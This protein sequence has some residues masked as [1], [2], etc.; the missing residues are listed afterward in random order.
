M[1]RA[2]ENLRKKLESM[3]PVVPGKRTDWNQRYL[4][5]QI[6]DLRKKKKAR[7]A[8]RRLRMEAQAAI[9]ARQAALDAKLAAKLKLRNRF[10]EAG[11][12]WKEYLTKDPSKAK[13]VKQQWQGLLPEFAATRGDERVVLVDL[14]ANGLELSEENP[15]R[16]R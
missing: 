2:I 14:L 1:S 7:R 15:E 4:G 16:L 3:P 5:E 6:E 8:E 13:V 12:S 9:D 10:E 11:L